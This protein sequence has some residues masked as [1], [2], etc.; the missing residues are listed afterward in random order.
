[1]ESRDFSIKEAFRFGVRGLTA[2][3][4]IF[5]PLFLIISFLTTILLVFFNYMSHAGGWGLVIQLRGMFPSVSWRWAPYLLEFAAFIIY[6]VSI[7]IAMTK[8]FLDIVDKKE[9]SI[10]DSFFGNS[11]LWPRLIM[12]NIL[13]ALMVSLFP[14]LSY[15]TAKMAGIDLFS[16]S[17][18]YSRQLYIVAMIFSVLL[19]YGFLFY[20]CLMIE[21]GCPVINAFKES[22]KIAHDNQRKIF[23]LGIVMILIIAIPQLIT[24]LSL[25]AWKASEAYATYRH[26]LAAQYFIVVFLQKIPAFV[27]GSIA[28]LSFTYTYRQLAGK[29]KDDDVFNVERYLKEEG[30]NGG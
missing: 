28:G 10:G 24:S 29:P 8:I 15:F 16:Q 1:M 6:S 9:P 26:N 5:I 7:Q 30:Q 23:L 2:H 27:S 3:P 21:R 17:P 20:H 22:L 19:L 18:D 11:H 4:N 13:F 14:A 12:A 25:R